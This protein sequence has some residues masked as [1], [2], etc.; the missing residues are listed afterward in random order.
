MKPKKLELFPIKAF[1]RILSD[2]VLN[3]RK[4]P[5]YESYVARSADQE[6]RKE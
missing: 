6:I 5:C 2:E 1:P 4:T 3:K